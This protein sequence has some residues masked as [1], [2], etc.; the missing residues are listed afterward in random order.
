MRLNADCVFE[1]LLKQKVLECKAAGWKNTSA[2]QT[3][4]YICEFFIEKNKLR[5]IQSFQISI[6]G[7][8]HWLFANSIECLLSS[9]NDEAR[10]HIQKVLIQC[11]YKE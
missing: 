1:N 4:P 5:C 6:E 9:C 2:S 10:R 8:N 7:G 3:A 11:M